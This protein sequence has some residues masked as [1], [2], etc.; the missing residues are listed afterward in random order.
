MSREV[1]NLIRALHEP[2]LRGD[3]QMLRS[4]L[5]NTTPEH[6]SKV[7]GE[8][9]EFIRERPMSGEEFRNTTQVWVRDD[10]EL[11]RAAEDAYRFYFEDGP[12]PAYLDD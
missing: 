6:L 11:Y 9:S 7:K 12:V 4:S 3:Q 1:V 2:E 5:H 10:D 8:F